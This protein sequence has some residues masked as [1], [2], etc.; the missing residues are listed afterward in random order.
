MK[1]Q[2]ATR[3][4]NRSKLREH[5]NEFWYTESASNGITTV[6]TL[7]PTMAQQPFSGPRPPHY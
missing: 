7:F 3:N 5:K 1:L 2:Q 6:L 4:T